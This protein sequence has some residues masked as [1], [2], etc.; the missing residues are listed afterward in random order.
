MASVVY[1]GSNDPVQQNAINIFKD[2]DQLTFMCVPSN[3]DSSLFCGLNSYCKH[4][5]CES[6]L[7]NHCYEPVCNNSM[8][9]MAKRENVTIWERKS[10]DC[11]NFNATMKVDQYT[12][13]NATKLMKFVKTINAL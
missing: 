8:I 11:L 2:C 10:S 6:F 4:E 7:R 3:Y 12:G 13:S 1:L 5:A 9:S